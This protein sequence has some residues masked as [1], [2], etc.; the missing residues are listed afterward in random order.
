MFVDDRRPVGDWLSEN[1]IDNLSPTSDNHF[2]WWFFGG[3]QMIVDDRRPV[4]DWS[5]I[6]CQNSLSA[7][8]FR[9]SI[10]KPFADQTSRRNFFKH[11]LVGDRSPINRRSVA[12]QSSL[13]A[14]HFFLVSNN[15]TATKR[16]NCQV[17]NKGSYYNYLFVY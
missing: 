2:F 15:K 17:Q 13:V 7:R 14:H 1:Y 16:I 9:C 8:G 12:D 6:G 11:S 10:E 4:G 5:A 3:R